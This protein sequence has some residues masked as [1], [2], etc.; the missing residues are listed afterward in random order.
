MTMPSMRSV[1]LFLLT[2]P[3]HVTSGIAVQGPSPGVTSVSP[4]GREFIGIFN[5]ASDR[6]RLVTVFSP[7]CGRCLKGAADI[8]NILRKVAGARIK[9]L[10]LWAPILGSDSR[11]A[12]QQATAYLRDPRAEHFWDLWN[13]GRQHYTKRFQYPKD[14]TAWDIFVLYKPHLAWHKSGP[15]PTVWLQDRGM[16]IGLKYTAELLHEH[17]K[18]WTR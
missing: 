13:F 9:V 5:A 1:L 2:A 8:Q 12:A 10:V 14:S 18:T 16:D 17:V 11:G 7:T 3:I 4:D 15:E 6:T